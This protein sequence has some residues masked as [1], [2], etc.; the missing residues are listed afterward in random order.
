MNCLTKSDH[1]WS[2]LESDSDLDATNA[3]RIRNSLC[4]TLYGRLFTWLIGRI[5]ESL[6]VCPNSKFNWI[7]TDSDS[8]PAQT[9]FTARQTIG[10]LGFFRFRESHKQYVR[11]ICDQLL[12]RETASELC[13]K[14]HQESAGS[15]CTRWS[16]LESHRF[17]WQWDDRRFTGSAELRHFEF[18]RRSTCEEWRRNI[19]VAGA[20]MLCRSSELRFRWQRHSAEWFSVSSP[21]SSMNAKL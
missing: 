18:T 16:R 6:K 19:F 10:C 1:K 12:Q 3:A 5:N 15:V 7:E 17:L 13:A 2:C 4:R 14:C 11:T 21:V 20:S 8:I 9:Q